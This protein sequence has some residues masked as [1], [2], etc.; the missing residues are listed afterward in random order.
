MA[1]RQPT[2]GWSQ[3][4]HLGILTLFS[5]VSRGCVIN[6][7]RGISDFVRKEQ[8]AAKDV[9]RRGQRRGA[10]TSTG[11]AGG[12]TMNGTPPQSRRTV[13]K[14]IAALGVIRAAL[15]FASKVLH[16]RKARTHKRRVS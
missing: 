9:Q 14:T 11:N 2:H 8:S 16:S 15:G 7:E 4:L 13:V 10:H 6:M 5:P 1:A 12:T 3:A